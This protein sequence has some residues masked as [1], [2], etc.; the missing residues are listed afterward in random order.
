MNGMKRTVFYDR[1]KG[2][3]AKIVEFG[4]WEMPIQYPSG[5]VEEHLAT[6]KGA[7]LFD[8]S[9]MGRFIVRGTGAIKFLQHALTNNVEALN[10]R[11]TGAQYTL[12]SNETGG[13][14][15]D[16]Y[17]YNFVEGEY[18][19]FF[20][21]GKGDRIVVESGT[22]RG[23]Y[24]IANLLPRQYRARVASKQALIARMDRDLLEKEV[25]WGQLSHTSKK[26]E[27]PADNDWKITLLRTPTFSR[28]PM[29]NVQQ[30]FEELQE[31][32][33]KA[34]QVIIREGEPGDYY[35]IIRKGKCKVVRNVGV[36]EI[37]LGILE[38]ADA[39][40]DE[41]L[42]SGKPRNATVVMET[43]GMLMRLSK[44]NFQELMHT[45]LVKRIDLENAMRAV[46]EGKALLIDV[47]MEEEFTAN[48]LPHALNIPVFLLYLKTQSLNRRLK[49]IVYCDTGDCSE[50]AA[51]ILTRRG[52]DSYVLKQ[53]A[54]ALA[55]ANS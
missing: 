45:P 40:G 22:D 14:V 50:A 18:P 16:A 55:A 20:D 32:P 7:G 43:D 25:T 47:R 13:A 26:G 30:L 4:G 46:T 48:R 11:E 42:V 31:F 35:Y 51:F 39:F 6:R 44:A 2:L 49:Y 19:V 3:G 5:I 34:G 8:V 36:R 29:T 9:H 17:L 53:P 38:K 1:H 23:R 24:A 33:A 21:H 52:F 12:I 27:K 10:L 41:A 28:L 15:D 37:K 54:R